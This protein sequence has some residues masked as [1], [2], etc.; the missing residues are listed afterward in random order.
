MKSNNIHTFASAAL[1][2][3]LPIICGCSSNNCPL[4][5]TVLCNYHF[6]DSE[7]TAIKYGDTLT[8]STLLPGNKAVYVYR[9]FG[10]PTLTLDYMN[11]KLVDEGYTVT[12]QT[13]RRDT[14]LVNKA[15]GSSEVHIPMSYYN[16]A[17]TL[18][19]NYSS[20]SRNDTVIIDHTNHPFVE[21]PEC[22]SHQFHELTGISATDAAIDRIEIVN[23]H[24]NYEGNENIRIYFNGTAQ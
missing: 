17:D 24:V 19:F 22:G 12:E 10:T 15:F 4:E 14:I 20:I 7:G 11:P 3:L 9:K 2:L 6:Y 8:I 21:L 18:I 1:A 13:A 5:N 16:P 23:R